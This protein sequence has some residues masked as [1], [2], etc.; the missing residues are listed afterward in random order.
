M[1]STSYGF[2]LFVSVFGSVVA[3]SSSE[4]GTTGG[5]PA[6]ASTI[7]PGPVSP[8]PEQAS[9][10]AVCAGA[11]NTTFPAEIGKSCA[12]GSNVKLCVMSG[13]SCGTESS[14]VWDAAS[15]GD[16]AYCTIGCAVGAADSCPNGYACETQECSR[17]PAAVC[18]QRGRV[19]CTK[20]PEL[21]T[22]RFVQSHVLFSSKSTLVLT[23]TSDLAT[24]TVRQ[25]RGEKLL[26]VV[27]ATKGSRF[28][29][30]KL[31]SIGEEAF[32]GITDNGQNVR[33]LG[34]SAAGLEE[35]TSNVPVLAVVR[36][37]EGLRFLTTTSV[38][39]PGSGALTTFA[40]T[41]AVRNSY[42][43]VD[44]GALLGRCFDDT[45][46]TPTTICLTKDGV[47]A[48]TIPLP[49]G[50]TLPDRDVM[51]RG[52]SADDF[53]VVDSV[54]NVHRFQSAKWISDAL[55]PAASGFLARIGD[56]LFLSQRIDKM[57]SDTRDYVL[58]ENCWQ[59]TQKVPYFADSLGGVDY[60]YYRE[61]SFCAQTEPR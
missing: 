61:P 36:T 19:G 4:P 10:R 8:G 42:G 54:A 6:P 41:V 56:R 48:T 57:T 16:K 22:E 45:S 12:A 33:V 50:V 37:S 15:S 34:V 40:G 23:A 43:N 1:K 18:V 2:S 5:N 7:A 52:R 51:V 26:K 38:L 46:A 20:I 24:L 29:V 35:W 3:C 55:P 13:T 31:G 59:A 39:A 30:T 60:G 47:A 28:Q 27:G 49:A 53:M 58:K 11:A 44:D 21:G 32:F 9:P 14:C 17:G 25:F